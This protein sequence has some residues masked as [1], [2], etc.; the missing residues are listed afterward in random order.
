MTQQLL[1]LLNP[2][3]SPLQPLKSLL[4]LP[5]PLLNPLHLHRKLRI[6]LLQEPDPL[7]Q[8][9]ALAPLVSHHLVRLREQAARQLLDLR[10]HSVHFSLSG[11]TLRL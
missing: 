7:P 10:A 5:I 9:S 2:S 6:A 1:R 3:H 11:Q 4:P 8:T